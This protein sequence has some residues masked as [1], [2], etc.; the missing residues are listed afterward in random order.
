MVRTDFGST[1]DFARAVA[2]QA[3]GKIVAA[4]GGS[5][6]GGVSVDFALARYNADGSLDPTFG[7]GGKVVTNLYATEYANGVAIQ[8]DGKIIAVGAT[9]ATSGL[10]GYEFAVARYNPNGSLDTSFGGVGYVITPFTSTLDTAQSVLIQPDGKIV[11]AGV[12]NAGSPSTQDLA[13]ARYSP[14]GSLDASFD[15]DGKVQTQDPGAAGAWS[16]AI[17]PDGKLAVAGGIVARYNTD[18]SLDTASA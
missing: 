15:G 11:A 1:P 16:V 18:G 2:I 9:T 6:P 8:A 5:I 3:D 17:Q 10:N 13:L 7:A 14:D 12:A 4:G